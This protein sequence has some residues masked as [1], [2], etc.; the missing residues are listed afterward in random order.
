MTMTPTWLYKIY[1][2]RELIY[3][4][5]TDNLPRRFREHERDSAWYQEFDYMERMLFPD[6]ATAAVH[7][8]ILIKAF[9][10]KYNTV[11]NRGGMRSIFKRFNLV[12]PN[13]KL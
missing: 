7:E 12:Y 3:I 10:P 2:D 11:H 5:I 8:E 1:K 13:I 4:G 6:R 9:T